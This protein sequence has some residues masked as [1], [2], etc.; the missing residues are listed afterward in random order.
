MSSSVLIALSGGVDSSVAAYLT[1]Q[2][3]HTCTGA[4]MRLYDGDDNAS[5]SAITDARAICDHLQIPHEVL[6]LTATFTQQVI[7]PFI[8]AYERGWTPNPCIACNRH[9]KFACLLAHAQETGFNYVATGHYARIDYD[10]DTGHHLLKRAL[11]RS[12]DQS[13]VLYT[14]TQEQLAHT[15]FPLGG[16]TKE[17]VRE[18]ASAQGLP[19]AD[20]GE[21]QDIC[22][23]PN[24]DYG[25]FIRRTTGR[26]Y[27]PGDIVD[28]QGR[29]LGT[30]QGIIGFTIGQRKGIG[31]AAAQPLYVKEIDPQTATVVVG[32]EADLYGKVA[33]VE[34]INLIVS[35]SFE[36]AIR[37]TAKHRYRSPEQPVTV[38]QL[39][40]DRLE[41]VF[42]EP[43]KAIT[44]GQALIL[45][46]GDL[47][48]GGGTITGAH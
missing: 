3:G 14:L 33:T 40:E 2:A 48:L 36:G 24:H 31:I 21:S 19:T 45:Y 42:D 32:T 28:T 22:F 16:L 13:Y 12:K 11:D 4:T 27:P 37:A 5:A 17:Q 6:D 1:V 44:K 8:A 7:A 29:R 26:E 15:L 46:D 34:D 23:I 43:Q 25:A 20:K 9:L 39:E 18:L 35:G 38:T 10:K 30:H 41:V 47:V